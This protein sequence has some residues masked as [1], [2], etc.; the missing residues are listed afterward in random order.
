MNGLSNKGGE[1]GE[2]GEPGEA[3]SSPVFWEMIFNFQIGKIIFCN[4]NGSKVMMNLL[5]G[6]KSIEW[7]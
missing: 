1:L 7:R 4:T 5:F 6:K 2:P 3:D